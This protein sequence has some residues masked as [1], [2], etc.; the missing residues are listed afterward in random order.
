MYKKGYYVDKD[1]GASFR[2]YLKAEALI[3]NGEPENRFD[4]P[5]IPLSEGSK[6]NQGTFRLTSYEWGVMYDALLAASEILN[7]SKYA[8][9]Y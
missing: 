1:E 3:D 9:Y 5:K 7:D 8:A 2:A 4:N 6:L